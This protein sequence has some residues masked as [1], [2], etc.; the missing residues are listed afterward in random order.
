[1]NEENMKILE[2]LL[3]QN[4]IN[5]SYE[6]LKAMQ[7]CFWETLKMLSKQN[8]KAKKLSN[9]INEFDKWLLGEQM[10]FYRGPDNERLIRYGETK[11]KWLELKGDGSNGR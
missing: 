5:M 10:M 3:N 4:P 9:I 6:Q 11:S 7:D 2:E 8:K 1:M